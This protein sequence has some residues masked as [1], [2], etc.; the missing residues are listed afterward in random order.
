MAYSTY[1]IKPPASDAS[2]Q[3]SRHRQADFPIQI[4]QLAIPL[5]VVFQ[6]RESFDF[7]AAA[8]KTIL[9][10]CEASQVKGLNVQFGWNIADDLL[11][12][13]LF[14]KTDALGMLIRGAAVRNARG[15]NGWSPCMMVS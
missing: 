5:W 8:S 1:F 2:R 12:T 10:T 15:S 6:I 14:Q 3:I 13:A 7:D 4:V 9:Q 11:K